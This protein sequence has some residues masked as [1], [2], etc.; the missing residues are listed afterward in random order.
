MAIHTMTTRQKIQRCLQ[1][2]DFEKLFIDVLGWDYLKEPPLIISFENHNFTLRPLVEKRG[3]KVYVCHPGTQGNIPADPLLRKIERE[4]IKHAYEHIIIY[5]DREKT[6]Q[7]WQW[8][9]REQ[10]RSSATRLHRYYKGQSGEGLAQRLEAL[11]VAINEEDQLRTLEVMGRVTKA[12][13]VERVT[14]KFYDRF[15][16]EHTAFLQF[17]TGIT[18]QGDREWY[19]SLML[20]R[21]MFIYFIQRKGFLDTKSPQALDGDS[22]YLAN[23]LQSMQQ[24]QQQ[25]NQFQ[26][27]YRYFL[28]KLFHDGLSKREGER[29]SELR[30][31]LG[32]IPYLNGGLFDVHTLESA[33]PH[34]DIPD[35]AFERLFAFFNEF[36]WHLDNRPL[37][38]D[39]EINPDVLGYIFEKYINQKQMGAYYTK[40]DITGYISQNTIIPFIFDATEQKDLVAFRPDGSIWSL[41]RE[42]PDK[43]IYD[44]VKKGCDK[45]LPPEIEAGVHDVAQRG[46]WNKTATEEYALPTEIWREVAARRARYEEMR[47]KLASG[48][49]HSIN[50][51]ITYNL[52]ICKFA[53]DVIIY[54]E[55]PNLLLAFYNAIESVTVLDPT[56]GSGAF[57]FA[58]LN[59]LEP[60]YEACLDHMQN[61]VDERDQLNASIPV[62]QR[63]R[64][65][66]I[67]QFR[68][69]LSEA[70]QHPSRKYF[71]YKSIIINNLYGVDIM[72]EATEICKLRLFLKLV[73]QVEKFDDIEPLPD[74]DFNIRAGNTLVGFASHDETRKA[75][76]GK[77]VGKGIVRES[78]AYQDQMIFDDRMSRIEQKAQEI[79]RAFKDFRRIQT[80]L[81]QNPEDMAANKQQIRKMLKELGAELDGYLASEYGIDRNNIIQKDVY[82]EKLKHWQQTHRPFHWW[83]EFYGIMK[84]GGFDVIIGNPPYVS[85]RNINYM[86]LP[87]GST[88]FT[89]L[90]AYVISRSLELSIIHGHI[91]MIVPLSI[92]FSEDFGLLRS[93]V[94]STGQTWFSSYDNIPAALFAG[95]SQRCTIWLSVR[96]SQMLTFVAPM[97]RWRAEYRKFLTSNVSY[98]Q[99]END[100]FE[101]FGIPK[102]ASLKQFQVLENINSTHKL[103]S[104]HFSHQDRSGKVKLGF[105]QSARNFVSAF[106]EDPPCLDEQTLEK[107]PS[108]KIGYLSM[109]TD[110]VALV[111]LA[112]LAGEAFLWYWLVRGDG[113]DVTS[114]IVSDFL[115]VINAVSEQNLSLLKQLG[116]ILYRE[117][118]KALVFKKNAGKY[119]GNYNYRKLSHITRRADLLLFA[120]LG[121][122][123]SEA[124]EI[125]N[126]IQRVLSINEQAGEKSIPAEVKSKFSPELTDQNVQKRI[127]DEIDRVLAQH[128]GFTDEELDFIINY[129]IKYR[130]GRDSRDESEE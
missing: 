125:L 113:F 8:V 88:S 28:L 115:T 4:V 85:V 29:S 127:L 83:I 78:S 97:Y 51:L 64:Y 33:Y 22:N 121:I 95:V 116:Q 129:D 30:A 31:L 71:I 69:I 14:K 101:Q 99:I 75:L 32:N 24:G 92:T 105:S 66:A 50:D 60:L 45:P 58:A 82:D 107:I 67:E 6:A 23:R 80:E 96:S 112:S 56:C 26:T 84:K 102:L 49:I 21:L 109:R 5:I 19:A 74:I 53:G 118:F 124:L 39:K 120:G 106:L 18:A 123:R 36:D 55:G 57:L 3:V 89:D 10:G 103:P 7:V 111:A 130:M 108:S 44:A 48:E 91:G 43:Y 59:I 27:F 42:D 37:R 81:G 25:E 11:I 68:A 20:N 47:A 110:G 117:R 122:E 128:Y 16:L 15:K 61:L 63:R 17:I 2:F 38:N 119:V 62:A 100:G 76:Q 79:E 54:C 41:L 12:F 72:E 52:D 35:E 1:T 98:T 126:Y 93:I 86:L 94:Y 65:P 13:D 40:E 104:R 87:H 90:Y 9:K 77:T 70:E 114:W 73:S 46:A 34:I